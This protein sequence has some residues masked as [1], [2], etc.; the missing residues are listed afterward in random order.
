M[1]TPVVEK[2]VG[3]AAQYGDDDVAEMWKARDAQC[4]MGHMGDARTSPMPAFISPR[5]RRNTSPVSSWSPT[6]E[7]P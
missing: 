2:S 4:P 7:L 1:N 3:L 5:T 6:A